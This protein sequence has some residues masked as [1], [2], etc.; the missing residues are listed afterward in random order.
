MAALQFTLLALYKGAAAVAPYALMSQAVVAAQMP[1]T[2]L[3][4]PLWT[5][6]AGLYH[7]RAVASIRR[8]VSQYLMVAALYSLCV[9]VALIF[10]VNPLLAVVMKH[11]LTIGTSLRVGF[12]VACALGLLAGGNIGSV[13][14][15]MGL[16]GA[17]AVIGVAQL[18]LEVVLAIIL[19]PRYGAVGMLVSSLATWAIGVP[20]QFWLI[21][22]GL[23]ARAT[24]ALDAGVA[25]PTAW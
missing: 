11:P 7:G 4:Q 20:S 24:V 1:L 17:N 25:P 8:M 14:L 23:A 3:Q 21:R 16:T 6:L 2:V 5:R 22:R 15:A 12:S 19:V 9:G 13:V 18:T 10:L